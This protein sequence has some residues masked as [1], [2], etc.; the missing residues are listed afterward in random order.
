LS[1]Y[2][3]EP[4]KKAVAILRA[5]GT[6]CVAHQIKY[7][8]LVREAGDALFPAHTREGVGCVSFSPLA[9]GLL[10]DKY[11]HGIPAGSRA[12]KQGSLPLDFITQNL[13][14]VKRLNDIATQRE[15]TLAQ[16]AIAWQ[17]Y[18]GRVT[19]VLVGVSSGKQ[20]DDNLAALKNTTFSAAE[21]TAINE[22]LHATE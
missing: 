2:P 16:M 8:M 21:L 1:N 22:I 6:P 7:S 11:L 3:A 9:Q 19:S 15:Q 18:D 14:K 5:L 4:F 20:L 17:L 10:S 12:S 13:H